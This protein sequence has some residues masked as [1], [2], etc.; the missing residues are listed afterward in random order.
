MANDTAVN[1]LA[2]AVMTEKGLS[3]KGFIMEP[4]IDKCEGCDR[5]V[6][7]EAAKYCPSYANPTRK[8]AH[9]ICNF[10]T[11]VKAE[12]TKTGEVK[13]NPLK[14]SKRAARGR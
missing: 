8:W 4:I 3:Y 5:A 6:A 1:A 2:G 12:K 11:H 7:V 9:G 14:A 13:I 10:A